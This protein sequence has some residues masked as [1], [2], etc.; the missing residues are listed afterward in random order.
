MAI[1]KSNL[2]EED[3]K[4]LIEENKI[5]KED[6]EAVNG[7]Y[8]YRGDGKYEVINDMTGEVMEVVCPGSFLDTKQRAIELGQL[9]MEITWE[10]LDMLR[11]GA[12]GHAVPVEKK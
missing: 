3:V 1:F 9:P 7:G 2:N 4:K 5:Q 12:V 6:L 10:F 8:T 11:S